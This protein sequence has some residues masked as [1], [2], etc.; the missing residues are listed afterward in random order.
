MAEAA[1][2]AYSPL[3]GWVFERAGSLPAPKFGIAKSGEYKGQYVNSFGC[4]CKQLPSEFPSLQ[5]LYTAPE[6][7]FNSLGYVKWAADFWWVPL[8]L[9]VAYLLLVHR[10][11]PAA[12]SGLEAVRCKNAWAIWN[13]L[14]SLFSLA[15]FL[16][17]FP[18]LVYFGSKWGYYASVCAPAETSFGQGAA[19]LWTML[20]IFSKVPEL[21]DTAFLILTKKRVDFLHWYHHFTVL[22]YCWH[23]YAT[24]SSAG[25]Y[26]VAMNYGV[27][28]IMYLYYFLTSCG[29]RPWWARAV[30]TLQISQMFVGMFVC[31]SVAYF[32][33]LVRIRGGRGCGQN[34]APFETRSH[35][36]THAP[37]FRW[38]RSYNPPFF[39]ARS[40]P[41]CA[42]H[43]GERKV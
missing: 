32:K 41:P 28:A 42:C 14:L 11:G 3:C 12:M 6:L 10:L 34:P 8:V 29:F 24:R 36:Y 17:T 2:P 43:A 22:L 23:S 20:F 4:V 27:H 18:H 35:T 21:V 25:L 15:G 40:L 31:V 13:L 16:R 5:P 9:S 19:G 33:W 39:H 30:T 7:N 38:Q 37:R 1:Q 26:F